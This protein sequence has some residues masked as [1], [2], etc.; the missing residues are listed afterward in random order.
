VDFLFLKTAFKM[1]FNVLVLYAIK[2]RYPYRKTEQCILSSIMSTPLA[3]LQ[4]RRGVKSMIWQAEI[5]A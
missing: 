3:R 5:Y 1:I 4:V 2:D